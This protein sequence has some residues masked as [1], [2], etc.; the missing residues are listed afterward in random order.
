MQDIEI[1]EYDY[2]RKVLEVKV[3]GENKTLMV[4]KITKNAIDDTL[5]LMVKE[6]KYVEL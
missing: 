1:I 2:E 4:D 5:R 3:L 6:G